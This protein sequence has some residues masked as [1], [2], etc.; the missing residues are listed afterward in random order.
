MTIPGFDEWAF[1]RILHSML[2]ARMGAR[3][4]LAAYTAEKGRFEAL[5]W[6]ELG[7]QPDEA[8]AVRRQFAA[9]FEVDAENGSGADD[10]FTRPVGDFIRTA[11][12]Q[13]RD[14]R[15]NVVFYTSGSTGEPKACSHH[16][17]HLYQE[18]TGI[19]PLLEGRERVIS[20]VPLHHLYGFT[21]G[22]LLP[23]GLGV[24]GVAEEALPTVAAA[25]MRPG[26]VVVGIPFLWALFAQGN[27]P[28]GRDIT[29]LTGT[30]PMPDGVFRALREKGFRIVEFYGASETGVVGFRQSEEEPF[31]LAPHLAGLEAES[32]G[33]VVLRR[34]LPDGRLVRYPLQD[35]V[36]LR[37]ERLFLP[38]GRKDNA[39]QVAGV[40]VYPERVARILSEHA[41]VRQC[42]VRP[43]KNHH[44]NRLKAFLV[45]ASGWD[46]RAL[47]EDIQRFARERLS[48]VERPVS[49]TVGSALPRNDMG[50][51]VDWK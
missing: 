3:R 10:V 20:C 39:V 23:A 44:G 43:L 32:K 6:S 37:G 50:K 7:C 30:A 13:W 11:W 19:F 45:P 21:F 35:Y 16:A 38:R 28:E 12:A 5:S 4:P 1:V 49:I 31:T 17:S 47:V 14:G 34:F 33:N 27:M 25:R 2:G 48:D 42:L 22:L 26:D 15:R 40:N 29:L 36:E 24:S 18:L 51:L 8:R 46:E 41:G 9:M